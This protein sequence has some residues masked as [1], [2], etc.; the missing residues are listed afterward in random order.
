[1]RKCRYS[2]DGLLTRRLTS[3]SLSSSGAAD[4]TMS[5]NSTPLMPHVWLR[6]EKTGNISDGNPN[7]RSVKG[8]TIRPIR[9]RNALLI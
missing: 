5:K 3:Q 9:R 2:R 4:S 8:R 7:Q 6:R 1:M